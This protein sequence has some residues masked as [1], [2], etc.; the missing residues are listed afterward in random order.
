MPRLKCN[1]IGAKSMKKQQNLLIVGA[2]IETL[3]TNWRETLSSDLH[4]TDQLWGI[5][6]FHLQFVLYIYI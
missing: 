4:I 6:F 5:Y 2:A 1:E 3:E